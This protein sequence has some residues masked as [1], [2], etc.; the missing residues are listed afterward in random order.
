MLGLLRSTSCGRPSPPYCWIC[1]VA[2]FIFSGRIYIFFAVLDKL[3]DELPLLEHVLVLGEL[4]ELLFLLE[5]IKG[6]AGKVM[7]VLET[8]LP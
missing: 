7:S 2:G 5:W 4:L 1:F 3:I 8:L 6:S